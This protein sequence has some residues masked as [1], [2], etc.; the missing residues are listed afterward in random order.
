[1]PSLLRRSDIEK[2]QLVCTF[3]V[4]PARKLNR[5]PGVGQALKADAFDHSSPFHIEARDYPL[6]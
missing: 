4:V 5:V 6:G 1:L 2:G 3:A